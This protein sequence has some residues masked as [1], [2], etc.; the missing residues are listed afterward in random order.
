MDPQHRDSMAF[1]RIVSGRFEKGMSVDHPRLGRRLRLPRA[2]R[3]FAQ[4]RETLEEAYAG[5]VLGLVNPGLFTIGDTVSEGGTFRFP[6]LPRFGPEHF[7]R[8]RP[9]SVDKQKAFQKGLK[10]LEEEGAIQILFEV[11]AIQ[12]A[13]ILAAVGELQ[14]DLV[15]SRLDKEY[16]VETIVD[17]LSYRSA[18]WIVGTAGGASPN[19][20]WPL[21]GILRARDDLGQLVALC[22]S[23]WTEQLLRDKN[24]DL[25][26]AA[27][28]DLAMR[29][30]G[31][32]A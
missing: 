24:P 30:S 27:I 31:R 32:R 26:F 4:E 11:G 10:Q 13:P 16:R 12:R 15:Q 14:F 9:T 3:I 8:L 2:H 18:L 29:P 7:A 23:R 5:D 20:V 19:V 22:E 17:R 1:L 21:N 25:E 6:P 28:L